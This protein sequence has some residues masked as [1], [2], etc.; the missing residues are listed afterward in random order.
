M[1]GSVASGTLCIIQ[2]FIGL[3]KSIV[4]A[5]MFGREEIMFHEF[6][7]SNVDNL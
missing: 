3:I 7:T 4:M 5:K 2:I 1:P 6:L